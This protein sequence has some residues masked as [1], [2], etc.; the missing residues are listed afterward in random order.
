MKAPNIENGN[1]LA[2]ERKRNDRD[3]REKSSVDEN[4]TLADMKVQRDEALKGNDLLGK[5]DFGGFAFVRGT[6]HVLRHRVGELVLRR[7]V[8]M[9]AQDG[10]HIRL[11]KHP[12]DKLALMFLRTVEVAGTVFWVDGLA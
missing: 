10:L 9:S 8:K 2:T 7:K 3:E 1:L 12:I 5:I 6:G 11:G 4:A